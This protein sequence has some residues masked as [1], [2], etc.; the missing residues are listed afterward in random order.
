LNDSDPSSQADESAQDSVEQFAADLKKLRLGAGHPTVARIQSEA[1]ISRTVLTA[2]FAGRALPSPR[3][4]AGIVKVC[5]GDVHGWLDRREALA[6]LSAD[7]INEVELA[8][9]DT[10]L[11]VPASRAISRRSAALLAVGTFLMGAIISA[12]A[13]SFVIVGWN[14]SQRNAGPQTVAFSGQDPAN[15]P[16]LD[17]AS[18]ATSET[19]ETDYLLEI[20]WSDKC[21]AGWGRIT[22]YDDLSYGNTVN[23]AIY[24]ASAAAGDDR[25]EATVVGVQGAYT[26]LIVRPKS[27]ALLCVEGSVTVEGRTI[28]LGEPLCT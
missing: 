7:L 16:C 22:R 17:D 21:Q 27:G 25:Q 4:V 28:D 6:H 10:P 9:D 19:R 18:V 8:D 24:P 14:M 13:T 1:G 23:V 5:G 11:E 15:S 2:A 3:T 26:A 20:I 12:V